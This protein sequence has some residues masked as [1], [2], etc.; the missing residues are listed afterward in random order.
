[1]LP[2]QGKPPVPANKWEGTLNAEKEGNTCIQSS[3]IFDNL[4]LIGDED[5]LYLNVYTPQPPSEVKVRKAIMV[6]IHGGGFHFGSGSREWG[7]P[8]YLMNY[9][10]ILV[11][12]NY[13]LHAL[14]DLI[15]VHGDD[16]SYLFY[17]PSVRRNLTFIKS[18]DLKV[19]H[20][21]CLLWTNFA[22]TGDPTYGMDANWKPSTSSKPTYLKISL[23]LKLVKGK[24]HERGN[25][26]WTELFKSEKL[27]F[28]NSKYL[29]DI[30]QLQKTILAQHIAKT[31]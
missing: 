11:T 9:D 12:L 29:Y 26:F 27:P 17:L 22:K 28:R 18:N 30:S 16:L 3:L 24:I 31:I 5:C 1:M 23:D 6:W 14:D 15:P 10:V 2:G 13:R 7:S 19:I 8:D 21:M 25:S 4:K 20:Q